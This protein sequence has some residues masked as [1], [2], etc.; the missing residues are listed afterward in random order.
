MSKAI[1]Y[2][3]LPN[4]EAIRVMDFP[5]LEEMDAFTKKFS[6]V[7]DLRNSSSIKWILEPYSDQFN[8]KQCRFVLFFIEDNDKKD[9]IP[10]ILDDSRPIITIKNTFNGNVLPE[11]ERARKLLYSSK[12]NSFLRNMMQEQWFSDTTGCLIRLK[13]YEAHELASA[14]FGLVHNSSDYYAKIEQIFEYRL[15]RKKLGYM[16]ELFED[17]LEMWK[18]KIEALPS[19]I[20]YYYSRNLRIGINSYYNGM[21]EQISISHFE[22]SKNLFEVVLEEGI[23]L[24]KGTGCYSGNQFIISGQ[25]T[26]VIIFPNK[27]QIKNAA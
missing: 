11:L 13:P 14:G 21:K 15:S 10:I 16:R 12:E 27:N 8:P 2:Y 7:D 18:E 23:V 20:L 1:L 24:N 4:K 19:D 25:K 17:S 5:S 3:I 26:K 22:Q 6:S 9:C